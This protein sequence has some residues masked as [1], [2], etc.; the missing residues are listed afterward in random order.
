MGA[1][2][3]T[4]Q[5]EHILQRPFGFQAHLQG[6]VAQKVFN[7]QAGFLQAQALRARHARAQV[8]HAQAVAIDQQ[9]TLHLR[10]LWQWQR[11]AALQLDAAGR[12]QVNTLFKGARN[13]KFT[14][15]C[16][17][18]GKHIQIPTG[19]EFDLAAF[20]LHQ[21]ITQVVAHVLRYIQRQVFVHFGHIGA[22]QAALQIEQTKVP[23]LLRQQLR[24]ARRLRGL[25]L[26]LCLALS[27]VVAELQV[28]QLQLDLR[29][30]R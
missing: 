7:T 13:A 10:E 9:L 8:F 1:A 21:R 11:R 2:K 29:H 23:F 3:T 25:P 14:L 27:V 15:L 26:D 4:R 30:G 6:G 17:G 16:G 12:G 20:A 22:R 28:G 24:R 19:F 18:E 5:G